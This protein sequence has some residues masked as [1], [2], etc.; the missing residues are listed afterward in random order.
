ME[1]QGKAF[2]GMNSGATES[3]VHLVW[4]R[5]ALRRPLLGHRALQRRKKRRRLLQRKAVETQAKGTVLRKKRQ[6]FHLQ[7]RFY[8]P[9]AGVG[10]RE[11]LCHLGPLR[12]GHHLGVSRGCKHARP[13]IDAPMSAVGCR[14]FGCSHRLI[15]VGCR[16]SGVGWWQLATGHWPP[17]PGQ[18]LTTAC[19]SWS[20]R[21]T[22]KQQDDTAQWAGR[23]RTKE[24]INPA[25][26]TLHPISLVQ[27]GRMAGRA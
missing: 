9:A 22:G 25:Q 21:D 4:W 11:P 26:S 6:W 8:R 27:D 1:P 23:A 16:L 14:L 15:A 7:R 12:V 13:S 17:A 24:M 20:A 19:Y 5:A 3:C 18:P 2:L 10:R